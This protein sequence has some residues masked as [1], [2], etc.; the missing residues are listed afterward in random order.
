MK[1]IRRRGAHGAGAPAALVLAML[2]GVPAFAASAHA[3]CAEPGPWQPS[4]PTPIS[5]QRVANVSVAR[6]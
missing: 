5:A 2:A 1:A 4:Q 6:S 3:T